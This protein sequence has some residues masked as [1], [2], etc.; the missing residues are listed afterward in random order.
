M[1]KTLLIL[2]TFGIVSCNT[3]N[4]S[5][6]INNLNINGLSLM[7][8]P[9]SWTEK[10]G[11]PDTIVDYE[12]ETDNEMWKD[13]QYKGNSFYFH[14]NKW[15]GFELRNE[16]FFFYKPEIKVGNNVNTVQSSFPNSYKNKA[17]INGLGFLIIDINY[18]DKRKDSDSFVVLNYDTSTN[19]IASI[20]LGT[21]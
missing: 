13:Y 8:T 15:V 21:K 11:N 14:Q 2:L 7:H 10:I 5:F 17:I 1:T 19:R 9:N 16:A 4:D 6:S 3:K 20:H 12:S 18:D